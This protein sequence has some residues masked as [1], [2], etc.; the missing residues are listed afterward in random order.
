MICSNCKNEITEDSKFCPFCGLAVIKPPSPPR[1]AAPTIEGKP[2]VKKRGAVYRWVI[3][4]LLAAL[5]AGNVY[6]L[7]VCS[8]QKQELA[9]ITSKYEAETRKNT[10]LNGDFTRVKNERDKF[11]K[12]NG[13]YTQIQEFLKQHGTEYKKDSAFHA[14]SNVIAVGKGQTVKLGVYYKGSR[15]TW[16]TYDGTYVDADWNDKTSGNTSH[17][18]ITGKKEG[19]SELEFS[20]GN[21]KKSDDKVIFRVLVIVI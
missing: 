2:E 12:T 7:T 9:Q 3:G 13:Y 1:A 6:Q 14:Y 8:R 15:Y 18:L 21:A 19:V 20:L 10:Q 16:V 4:L 5:L 17:L 11:K